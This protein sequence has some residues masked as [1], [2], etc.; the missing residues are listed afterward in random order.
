MINAE[1]GPPQLCRVQEDI[2]EMIYIRN[3]YVNAEQTGDS[4]G[5]YPAHPPFFPPYLKLI[6][7]P[8]VAELSLTA[9]GSRICGPDLTGKN[10]WLMDRQFRPNMMNVIGSHPG[11]G[12]TLVALVLLWCKNAK[13]LKKDEL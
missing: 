9:S 12:T 7:P 3:G 11:I 8:T 1:A 6:H 13:Y 4:R 10:A 5:R 2:L